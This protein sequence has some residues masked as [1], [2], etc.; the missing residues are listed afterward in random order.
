MCVLFIYNNNNNNSVPSNYEYTYYGFQVRLYNYYYYY[1]IF[2]SQHDPLAS[3]SR[4]LYNVQPTIRPWE[5]V[6][7]FYLE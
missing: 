6:G 5:R 2:A 4:G 3:P 7:S 1:F